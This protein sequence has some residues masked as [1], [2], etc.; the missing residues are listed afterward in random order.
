VI[1]VLLAPIV[2]L[3]WLHTAYV[4]GLAADATLSPGEIDTNEDMS[5][6]GVV[7][8]SFAYGL[9]VLPHVLVGIGFALFA[10][11]TAAYTAIKSSNRS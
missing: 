11:A 7:I 3:F 1:V 6:W 2:G 10:P 5:G 4:S 8:L 9:L